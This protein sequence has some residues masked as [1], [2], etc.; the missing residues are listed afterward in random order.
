MHLV[1]LFIIV[2]A[3]NELIISIHVLFFLRRDLSEQVD[4]FGNALHLALFVPD[5]V[6]L[7]SVRLE[8]PDVL[9]CVIVNVRFFL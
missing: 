8:D 1:G 6:N 7:V 2:K 3:G 4:E 9:D 5:L